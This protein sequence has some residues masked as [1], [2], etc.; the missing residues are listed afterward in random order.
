MLFFY[1]KEHVVALSVASYKT[2]LADLLFKDL[3]ENFKL[4]I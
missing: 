4:K 3:K 2:Q 1:N